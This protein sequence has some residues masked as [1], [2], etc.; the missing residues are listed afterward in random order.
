MGGGGVGKAL[1]DPGEEVGG[2]VDAVLGGLGVAGH[3]VELGLGEA[4]REGQRPGQ[5]VGGQ[6]GL[7]RGADLR[8]GAAACFDGGLCQVGDHIGPETCV[9]ADNGAVNRSGYLSPDNAFFAE[10]HR[11]T[12]VGGH[13]EVW[14]IRYVVHIVVHA[15]HTGLLVAAQDQMDLA[16]GLGHQRAGDLHG[17]QD[18][19]R[20]TF[21]I[22]DAPAVEPSVLD[23]GG[24]GICEPALAGGDD[25]Q[26]GQDAKD[27]VPGAALNA[28][29]LALKVP[30]DEPGVPPHL[31]SVIQDPPDLGAVR[32]AGGGGVRLLDGID[33]DQFAGLIDDLLA[34]GLGKFQPIH[35]QV[36]LFYYL[37][38]ALK[39]SRSS[40]VRRLM[41]S[42]MVLTMAT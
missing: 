21:V 7:E 22:D 42:T 10:N 31:Q 3:A 8:L 25:V 24:K 6:I 40:M 15:A 12:V 23:G 41:T 4:V 1:A 32:G 36:S 26:M 34:L 17:G 20:G 30:G 14:K 11:E 5:L 33:R 18:G 39:R 27:L 28:A 9:K 29:H 35:K 19:H 37:R 16:L 38:L 2:G 13:A